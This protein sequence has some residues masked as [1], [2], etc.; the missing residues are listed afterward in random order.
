MRNELD[1]RFKIRRI[2]KSIDAD[3]AAALK[4]YNE[5]T[6]YEIKTNTNEITMW[7]DWKDNTV[8]F[9]SMFFVLYYADML[10]GFAMMT[11]IRSQRI[12]ILEYIAL[13]AQYRVNTV[14]FTY[15]NLLE[16]YLNT[17]QYDVAF[18]LNEVSNRRNGNDIDKE[19]QIFSK[20]LCIEGYGK[21][22]APYLTPPLGTNNYESSFDAFLFA[23]SAGNIHALER[24]TYLDIIKSIYFDYFLTWYTY[25]LPQNEVE[26]YSEMLNKC[27]DSI[28][29]KLG[30][31]TIVPVIYSECPILQNS[32]Q[33]V[34]TSGLP[35]T[36]QKKPKLVLYFLLA[37]LLIICPIIIVLCYN[38]VLSLLSIPMGA[39]SDIIG[40]CLGAILT[41]G[42]TLY[43]AKKKL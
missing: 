10:S 28:S 19:S 27:F 3:Y 31:I 16:S 25:V 41:A 9:E 15:I 36:V 17:N 30:T 7:L 12:V 43:I 42:A 38:Y 14:F 35:P 24:Q 21:V 29:K 13:A 1:Y 32:N 22:D 26:Q 20:L 2:E 33:I 8:P 34:K 18:L 39:A 37:M 4:I 6:P 5:T 40:N 23:K 11:Y